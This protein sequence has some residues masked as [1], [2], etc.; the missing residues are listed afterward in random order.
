LVRIDADFGRP[1]SAE[2]RP[3]IA[4]KRVVLASLILVSVP[5]VRQLMERMR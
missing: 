5:T 3:P 1:C 2:G 4:A